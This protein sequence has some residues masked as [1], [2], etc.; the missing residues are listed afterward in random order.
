MRPE[1]DVKWFLC[2]CV[3]MQRQIRSSPRP[4]EPPDET[5][6]LLM[7][8]AS[9]RGSVITAG[10]AGKSTVSFQKVP[11]ATR[12]NIVTDGQV[13]LVKVAATSTTSC[14]WKELASQCCVVRG[15]TLF[16]ECVMQVLTMLA[17]IT[18]KI[19]VVVPLDDNIT[20]VCVDR[21]HF[22]DAVSQPIPTSTTK[23]P[24]E[25]TTLLWCS[26]H[27]E[28]QGGCSIRRKHHHC[29]R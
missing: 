29:P 26:I 6:L 7:P 10:L 11:R 27:V 16:L 12:R 9:V 8:Y 19:K 22:E 5:T 17:P 21:F 15:T 25:S 24:A 1:Q 13:P 4:Y 23:V 14:T 20:N 28:D 3:S 2:L 18:M